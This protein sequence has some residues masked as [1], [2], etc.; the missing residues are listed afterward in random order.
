MA[1]NNGRGFGFEGMSCQGAE[2]LQLLQ[3]CKQ[4]LQVD[5]WVGKQI[6]DS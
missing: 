3:C 4:V 2:E 5:R 1:P 6:D